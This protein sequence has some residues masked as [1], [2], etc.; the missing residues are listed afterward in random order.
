MLSVE[1]DQPITL[2]APAPVVE[3]Q[4]VPAPPRRTSRRALIGWITGVVV[5]L[6][7]AAGIA[8]AQVSAHR[9]F[10]ASTGRLLSAVDEVE[11]AASDTRE[12]ADDGTR[13]VDAAT[14]IGEAAADG[15]VD[16]AARARFVEA[17][18]VLATAQTGAEELLSRPLGPYDVEKPFWA[19]ELLEE[20]ARLDADAEAVTAAAAAMT[21]AEESLGDAQD[22]VEAAGQALYASVVPLAPTIEAAHVSARALA[23]LDFRDA[24]TAVAEQTGVGPGAASAFAQYVQKSKELTSS[25]QSE[26]AEKSGPL[27]DTRLEIEAYARSIAGG[28]V[29]DFDWAPLVNGLGGRAGMAGTATWNTIRGGFSTITLSNS[30]AEN[31]PSADARALVAHEVGHSITSKCSDLF[32]SADQAANEEWATAWA[33]GMGHTAEGNGVQAYGYP[34]Q[35]MIDRAMACR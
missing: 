26:L 8:F 12:T 16:P 24:A 31:W 2:P 35:D 25:A 27:Y 9:A 1:H 5:V 28:V 29:L 34:S 10:D 13:T 20:S 30:V 23:V 3:P 11:A 32:D 4:S 33:I 15:L 22:A 18:T 6:L 17:T 7:L 21:E 14:V 19:W